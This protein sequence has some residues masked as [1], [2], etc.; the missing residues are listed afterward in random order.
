[1]KYSVVLAALGASAVMASPAGDVTPNTMFALDKRA[2]FPIPSSKGSVTYKSAQKISGTFD[3]GMKTYGRGVSCTGQAE[4]GDSDAVFILANGATLKNAII[5]KDQIEGVHCEGSCTVENVWWS[6][7]CEDALSLKGDG[8]AKIVG[9]GA[10]GA[11][12]KVIQHN[13]MGTVTIDGFTAV[14]FGKLYRSCGNCKKMGL[15]NVVV[16]NVKAYNGKSLVGINSNYGDKATITGT[17]A[18]SV[19]EICVEYQGTSPGNEPKKISSGPSDHCVYKTL[20][21][22]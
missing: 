1:M 12:D 16:K 3:G 8:N 13:G 10:S 6:D 17:C 20:S 7:V 14:D 19:K 5:G 9:G 4:G 22:C 15:R 21:S 11:A 2:S 18:T